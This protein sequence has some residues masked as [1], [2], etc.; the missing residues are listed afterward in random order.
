MDLLISTLF[1]IFRYRKFDSV[2]VRLRIAYSALRCTKWKGQNIVSLGVV[3][4]IF[5]TTESSPYQLYRSLCPCA[6]S[7]EGA[8]AWSFFVTRGLKSE[9]SS[10]EAAGPLSNLTISQ[11]SNRQ[12]PVLELWYVISNHYPRDNIRDSR[13]RQRGYSHLTIV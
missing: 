11:Q 6:W 10:T 8:R 13:V 2:L 5:S 9:G 4:P 3:S 12:R 7:L 1:P